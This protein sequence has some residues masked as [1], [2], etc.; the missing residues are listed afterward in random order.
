MRALLTSD[1]SPEATAALRA[2]SRLLTSADRHVD[3]LYVAAEPR[4]PK[5]GLINKRAYH[6]RA[7]AET[8]RILEDARQVLKEEG[9]DA[10]TLSETGSPASVIMSESED[11]DVTV[12][13]AKGC[14]VR[15]NVGLGPVASRIV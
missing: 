5:S 2:A 13:G 7:A 10:L 9:I 12:I 8:R 14:N 3:V 1:G 6:H 15:S 11:Y 4:A